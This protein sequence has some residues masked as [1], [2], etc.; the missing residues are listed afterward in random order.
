[1]SVDKYHKK[2]TIKVGSATSTASAADGDLLLN[3]ENDFVAEG[4]GDASIIAT[5]GDA[6]VTATAG[7]AKVT[8][9]AGDVEVTATAGDVKVTAA[10]GDVEVT[11]TAGDVEVTATAGDAKVT[12]T[13]GDVEV[14]AST[15]KLTASTEVLLEGLVKADDDIVIGTS[16]KLFKHDSAKECSVNIPAAAFSVIAGTPVLGIDGEYAQTGTGL[17]SYFIDLAPYL[18]DHCTIDSVYAYI[19][20]DTD[21]ETVELDLFSRAMPSPSSVSEHYDSATTNISSNGTI[22]PI[23]LGMPAYVYD[24][25]ASAFWAQLDFTIISSTLSTFWGLRLNCDFTDFFRPG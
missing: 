2:H 13:A 22:E 6:K 5:T 18:P 7:D 12:A 8:A 24:K 1:M 11:A 20:N 14:A 15:V 19:S 21:G 17:S 25:G 9:T 10:V 23:A 16:G 4:N 3:A